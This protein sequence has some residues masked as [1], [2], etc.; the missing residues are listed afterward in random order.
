MPKP[1]R[2]HKRMD[3]DFKVIK[4]CVELLSKSTS[5]RMLRANMVYLWDRFVA[6]PPQPGT[7]TGEESVVIHRDDS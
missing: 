4:G 5:P 6:H 7:P 1:K 3:P 2:S